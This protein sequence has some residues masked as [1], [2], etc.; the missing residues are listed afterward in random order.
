ML[1]DS[2][3]A[4]PYKQAAETDNGFLN[5]ANEYANNGCYVMDWAFNYTPNVDAYRAALVS[6]LNVYNADQT[7]ANWE[8]VKAAFVDGWAYQYAQI[9]G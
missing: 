1:V 4:M 8:Q 2:F 9:N 3:G 5:A 7:D 6:A